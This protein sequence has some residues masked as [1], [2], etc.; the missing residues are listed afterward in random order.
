MK[1]GLARQYLLEALAMKRP[2]EKRLKEQLNANKCILDSCGASI[3]SRGLCDAHLAKFYYAIRGKSDGP[4]RIEFEQR[5]IKQGLI[6][7]PGEQSRWK[8]T[9]PFEQ[10]A[11]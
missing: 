3:K 10:A 5:C 9:N 4:E 7:A 11:G 8:T 6:L 1:E 2:N